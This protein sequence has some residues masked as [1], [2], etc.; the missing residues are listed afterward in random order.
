MMY[1]KFIIAFLF[2]CELSY[3]QS[4][5]G[6]GNEIIS[7]INSA[8][9]GS[10]KINAQAFDRSSF[11]AKVQ[12]SLLCSTGKLKCNYNLSYKDALILSAD[13]SEFL[14]EGIFKE[15]AYAAYS[16]AV[17]LKTDNSDSPVIEWELEIQENKKFNSV[18]GDAPPTS[19]SNVTGVI[20]K[21]RN[22]VDDI[23]SEARDYLND[24]YTIKTGGVNLET[25]RLANS[26]SNE[27][28]SRAP[29]ICTV[30]AIDVP[31]NIVTTLPDLALEDTLI[32]LRD[33]NPADGPDPSA[34]GKINHGGR[35]YIKFTDLPTKK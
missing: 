32:Y 29:D 34:L 6:R 16:F 7:E 19:C 1:K 31:I 30:N 10:T 26:P 15:S 2:C 8:G 24:Q 33:L 23:L 20:T 22:E 21:I 25:P 27:S 35:Q 13:A 17:F 11:D 28:A 3:G 5:S 12:N 9:S 14:D 18:E 4:L